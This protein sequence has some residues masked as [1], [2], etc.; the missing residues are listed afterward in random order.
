VFHITAPYPL[1]NQV[2]KEMFCTGLLDIGPYLPSCP[3]VLASKV[4]GVA[5][6]ICDLPQ[7]LLEAISVTVLQHMSSSCW[8]LQTDEV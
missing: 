6:I 2:I 8:H 7:F 5:C 1:P 4:S 3:D